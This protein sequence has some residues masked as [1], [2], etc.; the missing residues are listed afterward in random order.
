MA[1]ASDDESLKDEV[2]KFIDALGFDPL[3]IGNIDNSAILESGQPA[4]GANLPIEELTQL[5]KR[6]DL[7]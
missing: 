4:F 6:K 3:Y 2:A 5:V 7:A 1:F